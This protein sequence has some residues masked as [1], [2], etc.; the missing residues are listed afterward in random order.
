MTRSTW[1]PTWLRRWRI[2]RPPCAPTTTRRSRWRGL[3]LTTMYQ[4]RHGKQRWKTKA[5][6]GQAKWQSVPRMSRISST[7]ID[8]RRG[9]ALMLKTWSPESGIRSLVYNVDELVMLDLLRKDVIGETLKARIEKLF[10]TYA[11]IERQSKL[12]IFRT[13]MAPIATCVRRKQIPPW[14]SRNKVL[15][16]R[17]RT[18][19]I[20]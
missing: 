3:T 12:L 2:L 16:S 20:L 5:N 17:Q 8:Q 6:C 19:S 15:H 11:A 4:Y 18:R 13:F 1:T 7:R 14:K 9:T 10:D